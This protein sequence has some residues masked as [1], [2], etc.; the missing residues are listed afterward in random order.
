[1]PSFSANS[2]AKLETCDARL[3][4][5]LKLA[6]LHV[7]FTITCGHR[8]KSDQDAA[9]SSGV[10]KL[11]W[12]NS[13]HNSTPSLAVDIAPCVN[14]K[15][16]WNDSDRF[17]NVGFFILGILTSHGVNARLGGDWDRDF[18]TTDEKFTDLPHIEVLT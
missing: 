18:S 2:L 4:K 14:G 12:P 1:M 16:D 15:I 10:S 17:K 13:K 5:A 9:F 6:I 8:T 7:D 11:K 3:Q